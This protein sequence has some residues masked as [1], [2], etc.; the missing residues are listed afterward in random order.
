MNENVN[1]LELVTQADLDAI[2]QEAELSAATVR[3]AG[4][5]AAPPLQPIE[6]F[7]HVYGI[8]PQ[9]LEAERQS[10]IAFNEETQAI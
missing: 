9:H 3:A 6:M 7:E 10:W 5:A 4:V 1:S 2:D 8:K